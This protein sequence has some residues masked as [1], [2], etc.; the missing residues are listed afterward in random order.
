MGVAEDGQLA[1]VP[2]PVEG[3]GAQALQ[4]PVTG[5]APRAFVGDDEALV[6]ETTDQVEHLDDVDVAVAA[7]T[8]SAAS[9]G[10]GP[11]NTQSRRNAVRSV[12][13]R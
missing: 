1:D 5:L 12:S 3:V 4:Q 11:A 9:R 8:A 7:T 6:G 13:S 10:N 2:G